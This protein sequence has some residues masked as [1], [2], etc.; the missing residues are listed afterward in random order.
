[1]AIIIGL[2]KELEDAADA[3]AFFHRGTY[4]DPPMFPRAVNLLRAKAALLRKPKAESE[5][6][7]K[8]VKAWVGKRRS[9]GNEI[10][11]DSKRIA[12]S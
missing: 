8:T 3:L 2:A 12:S 4:A 11:I 6:Q 9:K 1:M 7:K 5:K 10:R